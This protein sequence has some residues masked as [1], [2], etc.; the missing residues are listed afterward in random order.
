MKKSVSFGLS[1]EGTSWQ[2][3]NI[4]ETALTL[5]NGEIRVFETTA[6]I[7]DVTKSNFVELS[8][9]DSELHSNDIGVSNIVAESPQKLAVNM[10]DRAANDKCAENYLVNGGTINLS[11]AQMKIPKSPSCSSIVCTT[12]SSAFTDT[13]VK[14]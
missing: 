3:R 9:V 12:F 13:H 2:K 14:T 5:D 7:N 11:R 10:S 8:K 1:R 4:L 6:Q